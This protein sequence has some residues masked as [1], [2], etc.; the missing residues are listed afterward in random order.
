M[1]L[2]SIAQIA[3]SVLLIILILLQERSSAGG[4]GIFGGGG[5]GSFYQT[6]RGL[7][8][9]LFVATIILAVIFAGLALLNLVL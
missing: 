3:T 1:D 2:L 6:R 7:E 5:D 4:L 9:T 8:K